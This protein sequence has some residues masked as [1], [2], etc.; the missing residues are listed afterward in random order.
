MLYYINLLTV[1]WI[2]IAV[3]VSPCGLGPENTFV[4]LFIDWIMDIYSLYRSQALW[5]GMVV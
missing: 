4:H 1:L 5:V 3:G 2:Y